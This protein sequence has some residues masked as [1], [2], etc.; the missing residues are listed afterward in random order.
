MRQCGLIACLSWVT[1]SMVIVFASGSARTRISRSVPAFNA[2]CTMRKV[3]VCQMRTL[4][5]EDLHWQ[6]KQMQPCSLT[7]GFCN[8][9][10]CTQMTWHTALY[11][12]HAVRPA[13]NDCVQNHV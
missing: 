6:A 11:L 9:T 13:H 8:G 7:K 5:E 12:Q 1:H 10:S 3:R 4:S 2:S